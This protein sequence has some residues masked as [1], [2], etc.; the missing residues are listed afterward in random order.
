MRAQNSVS[1][2]VA[3]LYHV[4]PKR[5]TLCPGTTHEC[6]ATTDTLADNDP[7][8]SYSTPDRSITCK[9]KMLC[10]A[11]MCSTVPL[12]KYLVP[13]RTEGC[14]I[15]CADHGAICLSPFFSCCKFHIF[16]Q[17]ETKWLQI[18]PRHSPFSQYSGL[19]LKL[20]T[21][22]TGPHFRRFTTPKRAT[23]MSWTHMPPAM[24]SLKIRRQTKKRTTL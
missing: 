18:L 1:G 13:Y 10:Y 2:F 8:W 16:C 5:Q 11:I 12:L 17:N 9:Q 22:S 4:F 7:F 20:K 21:S 14:C 24:R 19:N 15:V 3:S 23:K 6:P